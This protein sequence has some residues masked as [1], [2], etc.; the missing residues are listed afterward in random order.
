MWASSICSSV[1]IDPSA[2][3]RPPVRATATVGALSAAA[4]SSGGRWL[5]A[6]LLV[7]VHQRRRG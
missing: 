6:Q 1:G 7:V 5:D 3:S 4:T 2:A